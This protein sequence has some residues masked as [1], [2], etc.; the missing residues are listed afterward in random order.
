ME[1]DGAINTSK[2]IDEKP[3]Q[4]SKAWLQI[5][6]QAQIRRV[7]H[8]FRAGVMKPLLNGTSVTSSRKIKGRPGSWFYIEHIEE[9]CRTNLLCSMCGQRTRRSMIVCSSRFDCWLS[10]TL[11]SLRFLQNRPK[12]A[13]VSHS[14]AWTTSI[15]RSLHLPVKVSLGRV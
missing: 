11:L 6:I 5:Q 4:R 7:R 9:S 12:V 14:L 3:N 15:C 13:Q 2:T 10:R 1:E 8:R